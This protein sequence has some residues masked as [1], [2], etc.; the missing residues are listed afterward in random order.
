MA[1]VSEELQ[2]VQE[3]WEAVEERQAG[4]AGTGEGGH[5]G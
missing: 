4:T 3:E 5:W 2:R 1:E